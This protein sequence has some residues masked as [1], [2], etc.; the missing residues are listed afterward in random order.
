MREISVNKRDGV[1][2]PAVLQVD[3]LQLVLSSGTVSAI[4]W[5]L[6]LQR[7]AGDP[8]AASRLLGV[9]HPAHGH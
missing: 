2:K 7:R 4:F 3:P 9:A 5:L 6:F 1:L 8:A